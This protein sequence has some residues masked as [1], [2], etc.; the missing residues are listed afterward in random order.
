MIAY[1]I[2]NNEL[3]LEIPLVIAFLY[4]EHFKVQC[5]EHLYL[6]FLVL[7]LVLKDVDIASLADDNTPFTTANN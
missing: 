4:L 5:Q 2:G 6:I 1:L 7:F 3:E